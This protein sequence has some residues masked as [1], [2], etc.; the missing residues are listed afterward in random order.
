MALHTGDVAGLY[1]VATRSAAR[2]QGLAAA[3]TVAAT[4]LAL[5]RGARVV[6]LQASPMG[7]PIYRRLG[8]QETGRIQRWSR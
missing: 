3:C 8:W 7:D 2:G 1:W 5:E 6:A 4:N